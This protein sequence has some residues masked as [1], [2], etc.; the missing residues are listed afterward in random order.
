MVA[1]DAIDME[2]VRK[3]IK[4]LINHGLDSEKPDRVTFQQCVITFE[5]SAELMGPVH[6]IARVFKAVTGLLKQEQVDCKQL[7]A[8]AKESCQNVAKFVDVVLPVHDKTWERRGNSRSTS[9]EQ[10]LHALDAGDFM[11]VLESAED[12][13]SLDQFFD[14]EIDLHTLQLYDE[15]DCILADHERQKFGSRSMRMLLAKDFNRCLMN[16]CKIEEMWRIL[17]LAFNEVETGDYETT[18]HRHHHSTPGIGMQSM[19]QLLESFDLNPTDE[20]HRQIFHQAIQSSATGATAESLLADSPVF[21]NRLLE[22]D[23]DDIA[24]LLYRSTVMRVLS[25]QNLQLLCRH[26]RRVKVKAG[27]IVRIKERA[28]VVIQSG[29]ATITY[30]DENNNTNLQHMERGD[31][32]GE[33]FAILDVAKITSL[34]ARSNSSVILISWKAFASMFEICPDL[35][36]N[37]CTAFVNQMEDTN[38]PHA[39]NL[40]AVEVRQIRGICKATAN[41]KGRETLTRISIDELQALQGKSQEQQERDSAMRKVMDRIHET[42]RVE[43]IDSK[44]KS[45]IFV[46]FAMWNGTFTSKLR[47]FTETVEHERRLSLKAGFEVIENSWTIISNGSNTVLFSQ[48]CSLKDHLGEVGVHFFAEAFPEDKTKQELEFRDWVMC[49]ICYLDGHDEKDDVENVEHVDAG[50]TDVVVLAKAV[51]VESK[52][53]KKIVS[54]F[55]SNWM[56]QKLVDTVALIRHTSIKPLFDDV[57]IAQAYKTTYTAI[58]GDVKNNLK[59][60]QVREFL[61]L[62]LIDFDHDLTELHVTE[63]FD[64]FSIDGSKGESVTWIDIERRLRERLNKGLDPHR[65]F[66][67][68]FSSSLNPSSP[69][70]RFWR[71]IQQVAALFSFM[72]VP[73]RIAFQPYPS[74]IS[75]DY[76]MVAMDLG[77]DCILALNLIV[78][79]HISYMNTKSRWVTDRGKIARHY[80]SK[81]F[82]VD[83]LCAAPVDWF[84]H[85]NGANQ[86][87]SSCFR[88]PKMLLVY[89]AFNEG[90][91]EG[92]VPVK[93]LGSQIKMSVHIVMLLHCATCIFFLLDNDGPKDDYTWYHYPANESDEWTSLE[94][95]Y[96]GFGYKEDPENSSHTRVWKQYLLSLYWVSST[97]TTTGIIGDMYPKSYSEVLFT[98]S[99]LICN[100]TLFSYVIGQVSANVLK[101]DEKLLKA[102]EELGAVESYLHSFD[103]SE[104]LKL[105]IKDYFHGATATSFLSAS[106]IFNSVSQSLRLEMSSELTRKC[107]DSCMLFRGCSEQMKDSIKGLLREVTFGN[108]EYLLQVNAV[109]HDMYFVMSGKVE[110]IN[111]DAEG[112]EILEARIEMGGCVGIL[113]SYFGIRYMY[114]ARAACPCLCL[115]LVRNQLMPI[116]KVTACVCVH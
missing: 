84:G 116:L 85:F 39:V 32:V 107:L 102:R 26:M 90:S 37:V 1:L 29:S 109:A 99:L 31:V 28:I 91:G 114:S 54:W 96:S 92:L 18:F 9:D 111:N 53:I 16:L 59:R 25:W 17:R 13:E 63:F 100:M 5:A 88:L 89:T 7:L 27:Q 78:K 4:L 81:E 97:V 71:S 94:Y 75:W 73:V 106:E 36:I 22:D 41:K 83:F 65:L 51:G 98:M 76:P 11:R 49:W 86:R 110:Q 52:E 70:I 6:E 60:F 66:L 80:L 64:V 82:L 57:K 48:L 95:E 56:L 58:A 23:S 113:S 8:S 14:F 35:Y 61:A 68:D 50:S 46:A 103:F 43:W 33:V 44:E 112:I 42:C 2:D 115:R 24:Q 34:S 62:L 93:H 101:G 40:K 69:V 12:P 87:L 45:V 15:L 105:E 108:E 55:G 47:K 38:I 79:F 74:M 20:E 3:V 21:Q 30:H 104:E 10:K 19:I 72:H 77:V 67:G